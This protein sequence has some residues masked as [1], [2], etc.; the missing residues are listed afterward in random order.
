MKM[1]GVSFGYVLFRLKAV[2]M[3]CQVA[4]WSQGSLIV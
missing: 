4:C 3:I 2:T 1:R